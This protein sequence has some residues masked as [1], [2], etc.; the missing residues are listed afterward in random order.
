MAVPFSIIVIDL[1]KN[2]FHVVGLDPHGTVLLRK[3]MNRGQ[4]SEFAATT[5]GSVVAIL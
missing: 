1:G 3:K 2:W 5:P 4:L